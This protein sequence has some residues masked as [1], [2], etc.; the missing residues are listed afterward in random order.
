M[1]DQHSIVHV[2]SEKLPDPHL[3]ELAVRM[4]KLTAQLDALRS[5]WRA[6]WRE[7]NGYEEEVTC[8]VA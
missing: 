2:Q 4:A 6:R 1:Q 3:T 7:V 5:E 8:H